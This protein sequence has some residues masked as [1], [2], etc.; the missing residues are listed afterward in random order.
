MSRLLVA[1]ARRA[2]AFLLALMLPGLACAQDKESNV[3]G[4][5]DTEH[6]FGFTEGAD[7]GEKGEK[8]LE[9]NTTG[10]LGKAGSYAVLLNETAFRYGVADGFRARACLQS[11]FLL[12]GKFDSRL[13]KKEAS[14]DSDVSKRRAVCA[15]FR[16][17]AWKS[18]RSGADCDKQSIVCRGGFVDRPHR[19]SLARSARRIR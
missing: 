18:Q 5:V 7:I 15:H 12:T 19:L 10:L 17:I 16:G 8:E 13:E 9:S 1:P 4:A 2:P 6:I 14:L 3:G 11:G